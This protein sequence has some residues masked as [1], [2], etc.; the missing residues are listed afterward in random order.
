MSAPL[1]AFHGDPAVKSKYLDR[2]KAHAQADEIV[3]GR[4]WENGKG[5]AVGCTIHCATHSAYETELGLP[6]WLAQ[7]EDVLFENLPNG[8]AKTFPAE[9]LSA[10][11]IGVNLESVKWKFCAFLLRENIERV[12]ALTLDYKLKDEVAASIRG[13]L[14]LH[15]NA[16]LKGKW[17][18]WACRSFWFVATSTT[19]GR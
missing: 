16:I 13:V 10:I 1:K 2:V 6:Q 17:S 9:F 5:C 15:E 8:E 3:K 4:Y 19:G 18:A 12:L 11:P 7:L 14:A